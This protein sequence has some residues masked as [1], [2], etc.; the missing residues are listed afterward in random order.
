MESD[1]SSV[2]RA[3]YPEYSELEPALDPEQAVTYPAWS[4]GNVLDVRSREN[5]RAGHL[6]PAVSIPVTP[7][8]DPAERLPAIFLP[9]RQEP[10][11][12]AAASSERLRTVC[13]FLHDRGRAEL[14][15]V[16]LDAAALAALPPEMVATGANRRHLWR[17]PVFLQQYAGL[18]PPPVVGRILDCGAGSCRA[19]VWLAE[20]GYRVT[21]VD[22]LDDALALG[23]RLA[24]D[25]SV[26]CD[27]LTRD[28]GDPDQ[29]PS[30]PWSVVLAFRYLERSLLQRLP[31]LLLPGGLVLV[32]TFRQPIGETRT[33]PRRHLL[34]PGELLQLV[35]PG[36]FEILVHEHDWF[37][38]NRPMSG[39][40]ARLVG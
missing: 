8:D 13:E 38:E 18:L 33:D 35:S 40:V 24:A 39:I 20:Q 21:A 10:L 36:P 11:L 34:K 16:V 19:A 22:R 5:Y 9:P 25:R 30:G 32:C 1:S 31:E 27:F 23:R 12:V 17:P 2:N 4:L 7:A 28:L 6:A 37:E 3:D 29:V 26:Q 15:G 14:N